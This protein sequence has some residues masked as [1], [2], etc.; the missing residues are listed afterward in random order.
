[1]KAFC[2]QKH[3]SY[4]LCIICIN[5][6]I[7]SAD[8]FVNR[9]RVFLEVFASYKINE[10]SIGAALV[11]L[12]LNYM[13]YFVKISLGVFLSR[14]TIGKIPHTSPVERMTASTTRAY[15]KG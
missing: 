1:M 7:P 10:D 15:H 8:E 11:F 12:N 13:S 3:P 4:P 14:L 5:I 6:I 9:G 2:P